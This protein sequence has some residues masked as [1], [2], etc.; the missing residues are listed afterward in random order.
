MLCTV[1][2]NQSVQHP[3]QFVIVYTGSLFVT[4]CNCLF[5]T[6]TPA[7]SQI[8]HLLELSVC[9]RR[10]VVRLHGSGWPCWVTMIHVLRNV[11]LEPDFKQ[12]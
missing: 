6:T 7:S 5:Y 3:K 1:V 10:S 8:S 9:I 4:T 2:S 11:L 12:K